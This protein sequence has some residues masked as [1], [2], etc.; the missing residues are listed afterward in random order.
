MEIIFAVF[1]GAVI[2]LSGVFLGGWFVFRTKREAEPLIMSNRGNSFSLDEP[3]FE[4]P[5]PP[6]PV[7]E[8][9]DGFVNHFA[10]SLK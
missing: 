2:A 6:E 3:E 9:M 1:V 5:P 10:A 4:A 8:A 7:K